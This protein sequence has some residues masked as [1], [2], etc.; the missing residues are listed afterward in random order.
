ML[1]ATPAAVRKSVLDTFEAGFPKAAICVVSSKE[2][3]EAAN[4]ERP[5]SPLA[6]EEILPQ[7]SGGTEG[8]LPLRKPPGPSGPR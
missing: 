2:K 7:V 5:E 6:I 8:S 4:A 1:A 3:L